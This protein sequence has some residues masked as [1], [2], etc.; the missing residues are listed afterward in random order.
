MHALLVVPLFFSPTSK[1]PVSYSQLYSLLAIASLLNRLRLYSGLD[2]FPTDLSSAQEFAKSLYRTFYSHPAQSSI[3]ADV[4]CSTLSFLVW[5]LVDF[6]R[7]SILQSA[8]LIGLFCATP[9]L[10]IATISSTY[11]VWRESWVEDVPEGRTVERST[12]LVK[13]KDL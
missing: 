10:G 6:R 8:G 1:G 13:G 2:S 9:V 3:S 5:M 12:K 4:V 7:K 11:L